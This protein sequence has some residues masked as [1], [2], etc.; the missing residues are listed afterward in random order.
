[1]TPYIIQILFL[2]LA[3][4]LFA[5]SIYMELARIILLA[6]G[7]AHALIRPK[8]LTMTF[9]LGDVLSFLLQCGGK[10]NPVSRK[11]IHDVPSVLTSYP[12]GG[13]MSTGSH[14]KSQNTVKI[15]QR[16]VVV[17]LL[18]QIL[19]FGCFVLVALLF[20]I[21]ISKTPTPQSMSDRIPWRKHL[22]ALYAASILILVR[23]VF[24]V[25]EFIQGNDG[26]IFGHEW[27][28][29]IFDSVLMLGVMTI[30]NIV[31]PSEVKALL[32]GGK[33]SRGG[34]KLYEVSASE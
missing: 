8:R 14:G 9:V 34:L 22:T 16:V 26:Y 28:L 27:F 15:G 24:R 23:S 1:L 4:V 5:A 30:F 12:G 33:L 2:L 18:V 7:E 17:G 19:F 6:D 31:H 3:P 11:G 29:Y 10:A 25:V 21:R 20:Q 32:R 13:L